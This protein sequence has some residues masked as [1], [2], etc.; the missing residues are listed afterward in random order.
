MSKLEIE[1][2]P[3]GINFYLN[4]IFGSDFIHDFGFGGVGIER[5]N[6]LAKVID[7]IRE[8]VGYEIISE[9]MSGGNGKVYSITSRSSVSSQSPS[10]ELERADTIETVREKISSEENLPP[11]QEKITIEIPTLKRENGSD[12]TW[13][14]S[15]DD[16]IHSD[17]LNVPENYDL[18]LLGNKTKSELYNYLIYNI[19]YKQFPWIPIKL[20]DGEDDIPKEILQY[21]NYP[22]NDEEIKCAQFITGDEATAI[23]LCKVNQIL[24]FHLDEYVSELMLHITSYIG[25]KILEEDEN[26]INLSNPYVFTEI[27]T[28]KNIV[29]NLPKIGRDGEGEGNEVEERKRTKLSAEEII[30]RQE[31]E[32]RAA[33]FEKIMGQVTP[34]QTAGDGPREPVNPIVMEIMKS[35]GILTNRI[36]QSETETEADSIMKNYSLIVIENIL[37]KYIELYSGRN[38]TIREDIKNTYWTLK[39]FN[40]QNKEDFKL[41]S[42]VRGQL[43]YIMENYIDVVKYE[44]R[45]LETGEQR[46]VFKNITYIMKELNLLIF[47]ESNFS[48]V[49]VSRKIRNDISNFY[50]VIKEDL[51]QLYRIINGNEPE[52][53]DYTGF[54]KQIL[55]PREWNEV[56]EETFP[57]DLL[58]ST[59]FRNEIKSI[60]LK[61]LITNGN[62]DEIPDEISDELIEGLVS[63]Q[64]GKRYGN[65]V[66]GDVTIE[67]CNEAAEIL[68]EI[69]SVSS[70]LKD[71]NLENITNKGREIMEQINDLVVRL[72]ISLFGPQSEWPTKTNK[73]FDNCKNKHNSLFNFV[74]K[75][76]TGGRAERNKLA[77]L[78]RLV[79]DIVEIYDKK[80]VNVYCKKIFAQQK[81]QQLE[82][83]R[84]L[85]EEANA[86]KRESEGKANK[87]WSNQLSMYVARA[88]LI[89]TETIANDERGTILIDNLNQ[90]K[91]SMRADKKTLGT[92][93]FYILHFLV[94]FNETNYSSKDYSPITVDVMRELFYNFQ[95]PFTQF[96][97]SIDDRTIKAA[98]TILNKYFSD[99]LISNNFNDESILAN[100]FSEWS[101]DKTGKKIINNAV[102][103]W[104]RGLSGKD[105]FC[106]MSS[107]NDAQSNCSSYISAVEKKILEVANM[108]VE[109]NTPDMAS[110]YNLKYNV[111]QSK[112]GDFD[113]CTVIVDAYIGN[114]MND[115]IT[116]SGENTVEKLYISETTNMNISSN[117][118]N[119]L[120]GAGNVLT[121]LLTSIEQLWRNFSPGITGTPFEKS[122]LCWNSMLTK[123]NY[124]NFLKSSH[125]KA[126]G[127]STQ[128]LN[129]ALI[130]GGY[131]SPGKRAYMGNTIHYYNRESEGI[132]KTNSILEGIIEPFDNNGNAG[133]GTLSNDRQ[134]GT[135]SLW[136]LMC[137]PENVINQKAFG[138]LS[139]NSDPTYRNSAGARGLVL[140][141]ALPRLGKALAKA[142]A[143]SA[144]KRGREQETEP[145]A[146]TRAK[147][148]TKIARQQEA[149]PQAK[150]RKTRG[151]NLKKRMRKTVK[152]MKN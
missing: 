129:G 123:H 134:S 103:N 24:A 10:S 99:K 142:P 150:K 76:L 135:R 95:L 42:K 117:S 80:V 122:E 43:N 31:S 13:K 8:I 66:G 71:V 107:I 146:K 45:P 60:V 48:D 81:Q 120:L 77:T 132:N 50:P 113:E 1:L 112:K 4:N 130:Y 141:S 37:N 7:R 148:T 116:P 30:R 101:S 52:N 58:Y 62:I 65:Q 46:I 38:I 127:D 32:K 19:L 3:Y 89:I 63:M 9:E 94:L 118:S 72:F 111:K 61:L 44:L 110:Y 114:G 126:L 11:G 92:W 53:Y 35:I 74:A 90:Y 91:P 15:I 49:S 87:L 88:A 121:N 152:K 75:K 6:D 79:S 33:R 27:P 86:L 84:Q 149:E 143:K 51:S 108:N 12:D 98:E 73:F 93:A 25:T 67:G 20:S 17:K 106:P 137:L 138:G 78:E 128:E 102:T 131:N 144:A 57:T 2:P 22:I 105:A 83:A 21:G 55:I 40:L 5:L 39:Q 14:Q 115:T 18:E 109:F 59:T 23:E 97:G 96:T 140:V 26:G 64:G 29:D 124:Y 82:E 133:R 136:L 125:L 151:G 69:K 147:T 56:N 54:L 47:E 16:M 68:D 70:G 36:N 34:T 85:K 139:V 104:P 145:S 119:K 28:F 100:N 41:F